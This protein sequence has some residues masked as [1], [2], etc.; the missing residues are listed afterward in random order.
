VLTINGIFDLTV[1]ISQHPDHV[2]I[3]NKEF[4]ETLVQ[5]AGFTVRE[6][7]TRRPGL[8]REIHINAIKQQGGLI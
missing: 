2:Y 8:T 6:S 1:G 4:L 5:R 3:F 7:E